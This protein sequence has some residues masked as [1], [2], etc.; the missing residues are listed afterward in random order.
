MCHPISCPALRLWLTFTALAKQGVQIRVLTNSLEAT[1]VASVYAGYAKSR[2]PLLQ[3]GV[4]LY[5]IPRLLPDA[6]RQFKTAGRKP[7]SRS[8]SGLHAKTFSVDQSRVFV[9]SFNFD[10]RSEK[11]NTEMGFI[12]ESPLL[13]QRV[14]NAFLHTVPENAY[15]LGLSDSGHLYWIERERRGRASI[16]RRARYQFL[17]AR[18]CL[19]YFVAADRLAVM[20]G[21][22]MRIARGERPPAGSRWDAADKRSGQSG[23]YGSSLLPQLRRPVS[24]APSARS[25]KSTGSANFPAA[26]AETG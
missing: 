23:Y 18:T 24:S 22:Y 6:V 19:D 8:K 21:G 2:K 13:A 3:A 1:D 17:E 11:L 16:R 10:P 5:E 9:G 26:T 20:R 12:I 4:Q 14:S 25:C 7:S 15:Q